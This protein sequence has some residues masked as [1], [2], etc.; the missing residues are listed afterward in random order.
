M[1]T[2]AVHVVLRLSGNRTDIP[3]LLPLQDQPADNDIYKD[4]LPARLQPMPTINSSE[5]YIYTANFYCPGRLRSRRSI[6]A[7][8]QAFRD[9]IFL[10]TGV[11]ITFLRSFDST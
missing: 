5:E 9:A 10:Y 8:A 11:K 7:V 1:R 2:R 6:I 3:E 4:E